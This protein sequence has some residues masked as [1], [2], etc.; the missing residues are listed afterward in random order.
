LPDPGAAGEALVSTG[1]AWTSG[2]AGGNYIMQTLTSPGTWTKPAGLKAVKVTVIGAGGNGGSGVAPST[3][4][5]SG[6]AGG[7][8]AIRYLDA[9]SIPGPVAVTVGTP[10]S[11][12][13]SFGA[14]ATATG[15]GNGANSTGSAFGRFI[16]TGGNGSAGDVNARGEDVGQQFD[17][18]SNNRGFFSRGGASAFGFA[19]AVNTNNVGAGAAGYAYGGGGAGA[20]GPTSAAGG[21]G[22]AGVVIVEEFY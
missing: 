21:Q 9:S 15:G 5:G 14:F 8:G 16:T 3:L 4:P 7:G 22:G 19:S 11:K 20:R 17:A 6:G 12:T 2:N 10:S 13:S 1:T 18:E